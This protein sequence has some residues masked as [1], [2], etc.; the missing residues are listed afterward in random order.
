MRKKAA[1]GKAPSEATLATF[2]AEAAS[3]SSVSDNVHGLKL[4]DNGST[5]LFGDDDDEEEKINK[6]RREREMGGEGDLDEMEYENDFADDDEKIE[7]DGDDEEA[8]EMEVPHSLCLS[9]E[10]DYSLFDSGTSE[11]RISCCKQAS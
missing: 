6:K 1:G 5:D 7:Q 2:K 10:R 3:R 8:K 9:G 4:V 11:T